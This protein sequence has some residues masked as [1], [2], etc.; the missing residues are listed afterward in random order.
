MAV[1]DLQDGATIAIALLVREVELKRK[2]DGS[3]Y[4]RLVLADRTGTL[5][6]VVWDEAAACVALCRVGVPVHVTG[7]YA[8]HQRYGPQLVIG[9]VRA[10][11][12]G[13]VRLEDL[14]D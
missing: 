11:E 7:R 5:P 12:P 2:R 14:L 10:C 1:R 13:E 4:L 8:V 9:A 6:G 3:E